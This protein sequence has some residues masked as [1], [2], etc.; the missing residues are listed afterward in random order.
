MVDAYFTTRDGT[1]FEPTDHARGPWDE[2]ACHGGPPT[3]LIVRAIEAI[4]PAQRLARLTVELMRPVPV[5]GFRVQGQVRRPGRSVTL[6]EAEIFDD[7][8]VYVRAYGL[9][10]RRL[11]GFT[12]LTAPAPPPDFADAVPGPFPIHETRHGR[13]GFI[14]S[15]DVRY[16]VA[17]GS[18]GTGGPT[19]IWLRLR[20]PILDGE[21]PSPLQRL[22]PLADCGNGV[23]YNEYLDRVGFVNPDLTIAFHRE[24]VGEWHAA[25]VRSHWHTDGTGIS[26]AELFDVDGVVGRA[27][28][29]LLL[30]PAG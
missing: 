27:V 13:D 7:D 16:N 8:H 12:T 25:R 14:G 23:S 22:C 18:A 20:V 17:E 3:A 29:T 15:V 30:V 4:V 5:A 11:D 19:T 2:T 1:W 10:M 26:D 24:P 9:H 21:V 28:Q 6:T